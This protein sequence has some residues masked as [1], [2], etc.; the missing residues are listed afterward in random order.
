M[1]WE[2]IETPDLDLR[3]LA[4]ADLRARLSREPMLLLYSFLAAYFGL[5]LVRYIC[6]PRRRCLP[7]RLPD[8]P[9]LRAPLNALLT[10]LTPATSVWPASYAHIAELSIS[11]RAA[12]IRV[13][14]HTLFDDLVS[15]AVELRHP[16][17][18]LPAFISNA[19]C[20]QGWT[21]EPY[22]KFSW[23]L[24]VAFRTVCIRITCWNPLVWSQPLCPSGKLMY[25]LLLS[26]NAEIKLFHRA[27]ATREAIE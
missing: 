20:P 14:L 5:V 16:A 4:P 23:Y 1:Q 11:H 7:D 15:G 27:H 17:V 12:T 9:R 19:F 10:F 22:I 21:V 2:H 6:F 24:Y 25:A 18:D 8:D 13:P 26:M 3:R